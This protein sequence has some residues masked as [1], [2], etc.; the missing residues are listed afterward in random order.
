MNVG[1]DAD[2]DMGAMDKDM[3]ST[4]L[5]SVLFGGRKVLQESFLV[6]MWRRCGGW[7]YV[8]CVHNCFKC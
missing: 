6:G 8:I 3:M 1:Q 5:W 7:V 4:A 2:S